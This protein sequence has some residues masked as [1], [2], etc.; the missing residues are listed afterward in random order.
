MILAADVGNTCVK[1]ALVGRDGIQRVWRLATAELGTAHACRLAVRDLDVGCLRGAVVGGVVPAAIRLLSPAIERTL[2]VNVHVVT[3]D[4]RMPLRNRYAVPRQLG[5]DRLAGACG[6]VALEGAPLVVVDAGTAITVDIV[7]RRREFLGGAILPGIAVGASALA[8]HTARLP[9]V[10]LIDPPRAIGRTTDENIRSGLFI[11]AAG[12]VDAVIRRCWK[13][14]GYR[15]RVIGTG[16]FA[17][18]IR[19]HSSLVK[20][21]EPGLTLLGLA[22]IWERNR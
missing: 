7:S 10:D 18:A 9:H 8:L 4:S 12:A 14:L 16:G 15:T 13:E 20:R 5:I 17:D 11:G 19:A 3:H 21:V 1:L 22:A 2:G 6:G